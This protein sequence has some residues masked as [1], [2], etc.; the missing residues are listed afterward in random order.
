M[1]F[2]E[3]IKNGRTQDGTYRRRR[4]ECKECGHNEIIHADGGRD[5]EP[6]RKIERDERKNR[7]RD[8]SNKHE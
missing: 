7:Q 3:R 8:K 5:V 1:T 4:F 2:K 6:F